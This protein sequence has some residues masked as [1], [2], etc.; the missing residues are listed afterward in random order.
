[1][2]HVVGRVVAA[3][4]SRG[5]GPCQWPGRYRCVQVN[6]PWVPCAS[7]SGYLVMDSGFPQNLFGNE[8][9]FANLDFDW[10]FSQPSDSAG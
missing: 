1:M 7:C 6:V 5:F 2:T 3:D 10:R 8:D 4:K 9:W